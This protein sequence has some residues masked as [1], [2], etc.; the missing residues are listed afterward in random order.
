[1]AVQ[2]RIW[3][4]FMRRR[5]REEDSGTAVP[6]MQAQSVDR[7]PLDIAPYDPLI[8][9]FQTK[10][11]SVDIEHLDLDSPA[12]EEMRTAGSGW[13]CLSSAKVSWSACS[14]SGRV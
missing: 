14:T 7:A 13:S 10:A 8:A 2:G 4:G 3:P 6:V 12:L 1:M 5:R 11:G 9:Y